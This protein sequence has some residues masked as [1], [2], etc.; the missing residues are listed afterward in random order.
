M[1]KEI[2]D[3]LHGLREDRGWT[4]KPIW[5][6]IGDGL[7]RYSKYVYQIEVLIQLIC[8]LNGRD[9]TTNMYFI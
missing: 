6:E 7:H 1:W 4:L 8:V 3:V 9:N 2:G 5:E